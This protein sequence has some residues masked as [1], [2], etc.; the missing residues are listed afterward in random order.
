LALEVPQGVWLDAIEIGSNGGFIK[1]AGKTFN[2]PL[3]MVLLQNLRS[4]SAFAD[5]QFKIF[6]LSVAVPKDSPGQKLANFTVQ[7]E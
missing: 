7:T 2:S 1:L 3:A 5:K 6:D 4:A